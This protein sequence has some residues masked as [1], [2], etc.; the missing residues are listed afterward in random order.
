MPKKLIL[1]KLGVS[2]LTSEVLQSKQTTPNFKSW[3][4][5]ISKTGMKCYNLHSYKQKSY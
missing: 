2:R 3:R 1:K 5:C 4:D